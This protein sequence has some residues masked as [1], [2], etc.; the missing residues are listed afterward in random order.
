MHLAALKSTHALT[1]GQ[2]TDTVNCDQAG[3]IASGGLDLHVMSQRMAQ[4][5]QFY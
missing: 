4:M 3:A 5:S 1:A 2:K